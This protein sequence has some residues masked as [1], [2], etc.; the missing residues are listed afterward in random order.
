MFR[1]LLLFLLFSFSVFPQTITVVTEDIPP[2]QYFID[3]K[4]DGRATR[5]VKAVLKEASLKG[6][7]YVFPWARTY[8]YAVNN[9]N[10]LIYPILRN[11]NREKNL[12]WVGVIGYFKMGFVHLKDRN[13][14]Q[15]NSVDEMKQWRLGVMRDDFTHH[16]LNEKGFKVNQNFILR[17]TFPELLGLLYA[18]KIDSVIGDLEIMRHMAKLSGY[19]ELDLEAE[20][21]PPTLT[22]DVYMAVNKDT[23]AEIIETLQ[24]ALE[25]VR[26][27]P[28]YIDGFAVSQ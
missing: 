22:R 21:F 15:A 9:K 12:Q 11:E 27:R 10:T 28:E 23:D 24:K 18:K 3:D 2:L 16:F 1:F 19:D 17:G 13:E 6:D 25:K 4:L 5:I 8:Q 26:S 14:L 20:L 7:F